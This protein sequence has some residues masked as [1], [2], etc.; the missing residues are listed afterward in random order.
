M[1]AYPIRH[2]AASISLLPAQLRVN[3]GAANDGANAGIEPTGMRTASLC[4]LLRLTDELRAHVQAG[5]LLEAAGDQ[6]KRERL[7]RKF[8]ASPLRPSE[9]AA[10][11]E[12][13]CAIMDMDAAL[14]SCLELN[15][16][17]AIEDLVGL[18]KRKH[19][20]DAAQGTRAA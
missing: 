15:R 10:I 19:Q 7:L 18:Q 11:V 3:P 6:A 13:C 20:L 2:T 1:Q 8:F 14:L 9:R 4:Q 17:Q 12:V 16:A 5:R